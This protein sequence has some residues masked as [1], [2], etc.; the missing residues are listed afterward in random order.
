MGILVLQTKNELQNNAVLE[1]AKTMN[2]ETIT[3]EQLK[4]NITA[5]LINEGLS[6]GMIGLEKTKFLFDSLK[7]ES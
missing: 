7:N 5:L 1:L 4:A 2:I 3:P 6:T